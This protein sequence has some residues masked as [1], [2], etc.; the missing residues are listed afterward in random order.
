[1]RAYEFIS[2]EQEAYEAGAYRKAAGLAARNPWHAEHQREMH[3]AYHQGYDE[4]EVDPRLSGQDPI[5]ERLHRIRDSV[6][7]ADG[8]VD[9]VLVAE[10]IEEMACDRLLIENADTDLLQFIEELHQLLHTK[11]A[12]IGQ[13]YYVKIVGVVNNKLTVFTGA[14]GPKTLVEVVDQGAFYYYKFDD[15]S[16]YP[17]N[18][19]SDKST[20]TTFLF[21]TEETFDQFRSAIYLR[22]DVLVNEASIAW[23]RGKG[24]PKQQFRCTS[25]PRAGRVVSNLRQC[26]EH[27][28]PAK[29]AA[30]K[31]T[32]AKTKVRAA[33]RSKRTKRVNPMSKIITRM[34]KIKKKK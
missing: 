6:R 32:R 31:I 23:R 1:M 12:K 3:D 18:M 25:G 28:N 9:Y 19:I 2:K 26:G 24:K 21:D 16:K 30:M 29:A 27:P 17:N 11:N 34:N 20:I 22:T 14:A 7:Q 15:G 5:S 4:A 10:M 8:S 13:D 33:K